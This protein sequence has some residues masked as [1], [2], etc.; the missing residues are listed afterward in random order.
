MSVFSKI[1]KR[2]AT[3]A[4]PPQ[5]LAD[6]FAGGTTTDAGAMVNETTA[7]KFSAVFACTRVISETI[8]SLPLNVY[9][10]LPNGGKQRAT[11]HPLYNLLHSLAAPNL[12]S[13]NW[14]ATAQG[15]LCTWGNSYAEIER[16][17]A[18]RVIG[19]HIIPPN[20]V[21]VKLVDGEKSYTVTLPKGG[22]VV[23]SAADVLH[24]PAFGYNGMIGYSVIGMARES[25]GLGMA[26]E[27]FGSKFF[28]QGTNTGGVFEFPGKLK[29]DAYDRLKKQLAEKYEGL[30]KSHRALLLEEGM[31][32]TRIGIPPNDA[33]FLETRKFQVSEICRIFRVPPH[34]VQDLERATFSNIEHQDIGFAKHTIRPWCVLWEQELARQLLTDADIRQGYFIEFSLDAL[35]RGDIKSRYEAYAVGRQNGWLSANDVRNFENLNPIDGGEM[36]LVPLNMVPADSVRSAVPPPGVSAPSQVRSEIEDRADPKKKIKHRKRIIESSR[37]SFRR[38]ASAIVNREVKAVRSA[39]E[40]ELRSAGSFARWIEEFYADLP[41]HIRREF[42]PVVEM[43][44]VNVAAAAAEEVNS[45]PPTQEDIDAYVS[46]YVDTL[47]LR[48]TTSSLGQLRQLLAETP[49]EGLAD[50]IAKRTEEWSERRADKVEKNESYR[51]GNAFTRFALIGAGVTLLRWVTVSDN[52]PF[53]RQMNGKVVGVSE[54]FLDAGDGIDGEG[55]DGPLKIRGNHTHPPIHAGCDCMIVKG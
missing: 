10:R 19:L 40:K 23:L 36:Y 33:Q 1:F 6:W 14:R 2:A 34:M 52:C 24:I 11:E 25:I 7:L 3:L 22:Q 17:N 37:S 16:N 35:L 8:G 53:C 49:A 18:G 41:A 51:T 44:A 32:Y 31:K 38:A 43:L 4:N 13:F 26:A 46:S 12:T 39:A 27:T 5:W 9:K 21:A 50:A 48:W 30:G 20:R 29:D 54:N 42:L 45:S 15:H 28:G 55:K 47:S